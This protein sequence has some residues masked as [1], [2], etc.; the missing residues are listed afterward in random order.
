MREGFAKIPTG[1]R[2]RADVAPEATLSLLDEVNRRYNTHHDRDLLPGTNDCFREVIEEHL[3]RR[4]TSPHLLEC[5]AEDRKDLH[6][7]ICDAV[8]LARAD[9]TWKKVPKRPYSLATKFFHFLFPDTFAIVDEQAASSIASWRFFAFE[10]E[11]PAKANERVEFSFQ[12]LADKSASG[13][14]GV[15]EFYSLVW[16][17]ASTELRDEAL[18]VTRDVEQF[19]R[20]SPETGRARF[21]V[22]DLIDKLLWKASGN[23]IVLGIAQPP[24][25]AQP[26]VS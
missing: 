8:K 19:L 20:R 13:Y 5:A 24:R 15:L 2:F 6:R 22:L 23:P 17:A 1:A 18:R 16:D 25:S 14:L 3:Q 4:S 9:S 12:K 10:C 26:S 21:T 7:T 11:V